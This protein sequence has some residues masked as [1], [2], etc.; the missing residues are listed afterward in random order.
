L[1]LAKTFCS[2]NK[3]V[4]LLIF[5]S[6]YYQ[7]KAY[8]GLYDILVLNRDALYYVLDMWASLLLAWLIMH[9]SVPK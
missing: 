1:S 4:M 5:I 6:I 8:I 9:L 7:N 3:P 2:S